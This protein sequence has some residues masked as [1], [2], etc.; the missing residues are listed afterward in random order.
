MWGMTR[1]SI[2]NGSKVPIVITLITALLLGIATVYRPPSKNFLT[3]RRPVTKQ[4]VENLPLMIAVGYLDEE[5]GTRI[6][7]YDSAD[8]KD[9]IGPGYHPIFQFASNEDRWVRVQDGWVESGN[10]DVINE[11]KA[12]G[13]TRK[14]EEVCV[15]SIHENQLTTMYPEQ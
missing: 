5:T 15:I 6:A 2:Q 10:F 3:N 7:P 8:V 4:Y 11:C 13:L 14:G 12:I 1:K 9:V